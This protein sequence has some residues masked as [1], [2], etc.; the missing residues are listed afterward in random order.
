MVRSSTTLDPELEEPIRAE[1]FGVDG[2]NS[3]LKVWR[4]PRPL[5]AI[6]GGAGYSRHESWRMDGSW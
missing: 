3:M 2:L 6:H 5:P 4:L 1:L